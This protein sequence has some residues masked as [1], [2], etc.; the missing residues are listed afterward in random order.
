MQTRHGFMTGFLRAVCLSGFIGS[1]LAGNLTPP[2]PPDSAESAMYTLESIWARLHDGTPGD[3][4]TTGYVGPAFGPDVSLAIP[5]L[6]QIMYA[7]PTR[8]DERGVT[9]TQVPTGKT[10]WGLTTSEWG[11]RTGTGTRVLSPDSYVVEAGYYE[12]TDLREVDG[13]LTAE[14]IVEGVAIFGVE[15]TAQIGD[16]GVYPAP[17]AKTGQMTSTQM[18]DDGDFQKGV[19][20][21]SPRFTDHHDGTVTDNLTGLMWIKAPHTLSGN[22]GQH[23]WSDAVVFCNELTHAGHSDWRL[24]NVRE[25]LSLIDY[26]N[27]DPA[28]PH[29]HPF[30]IHFQSGYWY[31]SSTSTAGLTEYAWIAVYGVGY[32]TNAGTKTTWHYVWPVRAGE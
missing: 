17:L 24:P 23:T 32:A 8:D 18:G 10:F 27:Y 2:G 9:S 21:P 15:G 5:N 30:T 7:C 4:P 6:N 25:L 13:D 31:W 29:D 16:G 3:K 28:L 26:D 11:I 22:A 19:V 1:A 14:N 20:W 12:A